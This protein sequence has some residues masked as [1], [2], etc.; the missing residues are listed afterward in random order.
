MSNPFEIAKNTF[1][2]LSHEQLSQKRK[3][4]EIIGNSQSI[5]QFTGKEVQYRSVYQD[6]ENKHDK[7]KKFVYDDSYDWNFPPNH[8]F[9]QQEYD[10]EEWKE[11]WATLFRCGWRYMIYSL[12]SGYEFPTFQMPTHGA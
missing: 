6:L 5:V 12:H 3:F 8:E 4:F 9:I 2:E 10:M 7:R 1:H 11:V